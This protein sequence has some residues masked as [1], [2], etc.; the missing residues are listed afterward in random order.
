MLTTPFAPAAK[1]SAFAPPA[2]TRLRWPCLLLL[3][4]ILIIHG[5]ERFHLLHVP[6]ERDEGEYAYQGQLLLQGITPFSLAYSS[7]KFPG[8]YIIAA[9]GQALFGDP[10]AGLH[11]CLALTCSV[12]I[13][14]VFLLAKRIS[15]E[16]GAL[17][18]SAAFALLCVSHTVLGFAAHATQFEVT[19][20][21]AGLWVLE[22]A[23]EN[24]E[25]SW[26]FASGLLLGGAILVRQ[27]SITFLVFAVFVLV[28]RMGTGGPFPWHWTLRSAL[29]ILA[30]VVLPITALIVWLGFAGTLP[31]FLF[32]TVEYAFSYG[33]QL[34]L[35][36]SWQ[37]LV[38]ILPRII[39][40]NWPIWVMA[41]IG[42]A[43]L[44]WRRSRWT[45][46][47]FALCLASGIA[48][49]IGLY[50]REHYFI[51]ALPVISILFGCAVAPARIFVAA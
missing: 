33:S 3:A 18:S 14:F 8:M 40:A 6:L 31:R 17:A 47:L 37:N 36:A 22:V 9:A 11:V 15:G 35:K 25:R 39:G 49:T 30:G 44:V 29:T 10:P 41:A 43:V 27:P 1:Q 21:L 46:Y 5:W 28:L 19:F 4:G 38:L 24:H 42:A 20:I 13:L 51:Q 48:V 45:T 7:Q 34:S 50:F 32:W 16:V 12:S 23:L 26:F 2:I